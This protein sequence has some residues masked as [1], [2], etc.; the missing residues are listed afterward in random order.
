MAFGSGSFQ[1][2]LRNARAKPKPG[3]KGRTW[4][5][6]G[7][8]GARSAPTGRKGTEDYS[9]LKEER[10]LYGRNDFKKVKSGKVNL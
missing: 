9:V 3:G 7:S 1:A 8:A 6:N 10:R 2:F 5:E 4:A